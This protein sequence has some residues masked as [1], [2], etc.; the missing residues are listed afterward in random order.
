VLGDRALEQFRVP[1]RCERYPPL[2]PAKCLGPGVGVVWPLPCGK[3]SP[4]PRLPR[5]FVPSSSRPF[6]SSNRHQRAFS[7]AQ[8]LLGSK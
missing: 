5:Q 7:Q 3:T 8:D 4:L 2:D 6:Q 1:W